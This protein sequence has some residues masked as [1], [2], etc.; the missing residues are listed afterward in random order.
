MSQRM[1]SN[2]ITLHRHTV[3]SPVGPL[4]LSQ[5]A[6]GLQSLAWGGDDYDSETDVLAEAKRQ[7]QAYFT[8]ELKCFELPFAPMGTPFQQ[9]VWRGLRD[10]PYGT[11]VSYGALAAKLGTGPR[12][13]ARACA[14]NPLAIFIP[15][16]RVVGTMG[17]LTGYSGGQGVE[18]KRALLRLEGVVASS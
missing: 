3:A 1:D 9:K 13:V 6:N 8:G 2:S 5:G 16:H 7:L 14:N 10:I 15:C 12:A 18:T 4:I 17:A 11:T